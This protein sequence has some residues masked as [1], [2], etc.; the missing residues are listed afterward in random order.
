MSQTH[1]LAHGGRV[2]RTR[3]LTFTFNGHTY[4]GYEGDSLAAALLANGVHIIGRSFKY[5]RPR[6]IYAAG[7]EEPNAVLQIGATEAT[8]IPNVRATQQAL[9]QGLVATSTNGWPNVNTDMMGILGKVGG[10]LM[11]PGFYY[12]TFMYPKSFWMTY[13]K[14]IR[15]AA[16]LGRSPTQNDPDTYDY[17]NRHCDVLIVGAGPAGLAAAL[18]AARSG[19]R[20]IVADEQ[21]EF[22]GSLLDSRESLDGKPAMEWVASVVAELRGM[23]DVVLLPRATVNGYHDHNFL[24][25]HERLTDHLGDRAPIGLVRQRIHRVRAKRVVLATGAC[26]RPLVYGN[27]DVPGNMLAGA[28]STYVRR[29][30]VAPGRTLLLSTNNDHAYRV[31]LDWLDA[32]LPVVAI[33]DARSNPRGALV[34]EARAK[35]IRI[36]T[37]SAV[38][39]ARGSK[40]VTGARVAAIDLNTHRVTS[41]GEL[42]DCDLIATSGGY[43]P[44]VHLASHLGGKPVW[45]EDILG[46][47]PGDAPQKRVCVG[48]I[49]GVYRLGDS[50]ADGFEGGVRAACEAGFNAVE[51]VLPKA[52][53]HHQEP[54]LAL[55][56]VPHEKGTARAPKQFVDL[57]NDVT[58][59]A[60]EL[61]TREGFESVEHVKRYTALG[62]GTDQGKL[63]NVNG[64]AI[65]A[66][67]LNVSIPQMGT[68]MFRP[69]YTPVTFGAVAGRHCGHIF[70]PVRYTAL[71][72]WHVK[73][74]AAF[75][76][77]GQWKRPWYFPRPGEDL[78]AAVKRECQA[79]RDSV[80]MLDASTL[81]KIDIQGPDAREFLNRIYTN[82]WT[83]LDVG[84]ARYGLMCKEDGMVFDDGVTA[85]L[86][87]NHFVMTTTTGGAARVLQWLEL[88]QQTEWPELKVYFTSVTDH[89]ATLTLS[90]P[91]SRKLLSEVT[92]IDLDRDAFPFMSWKEGRVAGVP[93]RVFRISFT[94]E[95]SYE[96]NIQ[97]DYAMGVLEAIVEAGK[98]Y[99]LTPYGTET[100]HVLRAEKGFIIVGQDTDGSMTPDDLNM[101]WCVGRNKPF[102]WIGWRGM[103][104]EDCVREA[105]KQLV[106]LKPVNPTQW[107][108]EGAQLVFD[109]KQAIPMSMVGHVTSSY[110]CGSL[111]YSFAMG[112]VKD[113]LKRMGE[114]VFAPLADGSVIEAEIVS[115]VFFDP[116][117]ERQNI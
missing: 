11:P 48:G 72:A 95:L 33:A 93:A 63:G 60:I 67:S 83:K 66:R 100:M 105:R 85:C 57:Q 30:G 7:A 86:A 29:Y 101:G 82:A 106:G 52:L 1:R 27:N 96:V 37:G 64:L 28:V 17:M 59:A 116:K 84:K 81:G 90:G 15:K 68:T 36:L 24:T 98:A 117:G 69:N 78:H 65:A 114:R 51:G 42:L 102:S 50:L 10:K 41:P 26:E 71:Q 110:T 77:V 54:T 9:Y 34:E 38:I 62:F 91:N 31:A 74:G 75:E 108:P 88:Y 109:P 46:F 23:P 6:G 79:V 3:V 8:Q 20:V 92:D 16:G 19:A 70:E 43:S 22:G 47:V 103:N 99:N 55:F 112:V 73:Q 94:G 39:E 111:G 56:H 32:S 21:E 89:Y 107:L 18:A 80:G 53:N 13:E 4:T 49:N 2:D 104:R 40:H 87:D 61:A 12:K 25:I 58:A 5:S 113:G 35:G 76:D 14:Y 44:V 45:R 97:A 115:S